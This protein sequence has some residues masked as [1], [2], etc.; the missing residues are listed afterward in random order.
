MIRKSQRLSFQPQTARQREF[1]ARAG[2]RVDRIARH[3]HARRCLIH[4]N[5]NS[6]RCSTK[7]LISMLRVL[8]VIFIYLF[9]SLSLFLSADNATYVPTVRA[10]H[11]RTHMP[12]AFPFATPALF[13]SP[14]LRDL[15]DC[16]KMM[17]HRIPS[18][19]S[20]YV[21]RPA[22]LRPTRNS[23][24]DSAVIPAS[25]GYTRRVQRHDAYSIAAGRANTHKA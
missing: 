24:G 13:S 3:E 5:V 17:T 10:I 23:A 21:T 4:H 12:I 6:F 11:T 2:F 9:S 18:Q 15:V 19:F 25:R 1:S 20:R 7:P 8:A 14:L 22:L 16:Q